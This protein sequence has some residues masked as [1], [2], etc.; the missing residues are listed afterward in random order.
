[1]SLYVEAG[2]YSVVPFPY[3]SD[4]LWINWESK[5]INVPR[6]YM[7]LVQTTPSE[8]RE[9]NINTFRLDLKA[10]EYDEFGMVFDTTHSHNT[11][12]TIGGVTLA[13]VVEI[14]NGYTVTFENGTYSVNLVGA[15]S[16]IGDVTNLNNVQIRSANSAG[17][18]DASATEL[19]F[20]DLIAANLIS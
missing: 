15:N 7:T 19:T 2:Y 9:M 1:M 5:V 17:L 20:G 18:I 3:T 4:V 12:V 14:I 10:L 16:N 11:T 8:I 13:R 6:G